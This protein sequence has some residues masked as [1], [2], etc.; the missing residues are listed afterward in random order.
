MNKYSGIIFDFNGV[1]LWD[2]TLHE[3]TWNF[4]AK[5]LRNKPI[6]EHEFEFIIHGRPARYIIEYLIGRVPSQA[7]EDNIINEKENA[8]KIL[9]QRG[10]LFKLSP[11]AEDL[12]NY[13]VTKNIPHNIATSSGKS[14]LDFFVKYLKLEKWF[15]VSKIVYDDGSVRGKPYP[16]MYIKAAENINLTPQ[17]CIVVEDAVTGIT[18]AHEAQIGKIYALG[19][20]NRHHVLQDIPGVSEVI[21]NLGE[22]PKDI[23]KV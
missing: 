18:A 20:K 11:G 1:L 6:S 2:S 21:T 4:V 3:L 22:I 13:L 16:D 15:N 7:E 14:N 8:Y 5:K 23:F 9:L 17:E 10:E 12:L 19:P